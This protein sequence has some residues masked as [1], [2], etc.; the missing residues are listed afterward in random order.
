MPPSFD[1]LKLKQSASSDSDT[2]SASSSVGSDIGV[3]AH[4]TIGPP[5]T[6]T[7]IGAAG[8]RMTMPSYPRPDDALRAGEI[9]TPPNNIGHLALFNQHLQKSNREVEWIYSD[10]SSCSGGDVGGAGY[11]DMG[12][13]AEVMI[14]GTKT[15]PVWYVKVLVDG[16]LHGRGRGNTKRAARNEAAK[17]GLCKL[18]IVDI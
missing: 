18:G 16:T 17:E 10:G 3:R 12:L 13:P 14:C 8:T 7:T 15:T 2:S 1:K 11:N 4:S 9:L 6:T 5:T